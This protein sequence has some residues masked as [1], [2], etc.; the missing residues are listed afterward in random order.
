VHPAY[1]VI[2]FTTASGAGYGLLALMAVF[3]AAGALPPDLWLG[4]IGFGLSLGAITFGL[5][6]STFHL[7]HPERAWRAFSQWRSSWLSREGVASVATYVP[8]GLFGI[9]WVFLGDNRGVWAAFGLIAA[10]GAVATVACTAMIYASLKPIHAWSNPHVLPNYLALALLTGALWF[11]A[12][13]RVFGYWSPWVALVCVAAIIVAFWFKRAYWR[14]IDTTRGRPTVESATGLGALG[15]VRLLD[16]PNTQENYVQTEMGYTIA[17]KHA[18]KLRRI[19]FVGLFAVPL[20]LVLIGMD[21][22]AWLG[23]PCLVLAALSASAGVVVERWLFFAEAKH[24]VM[25]YYGADAA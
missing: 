10:A 12:L 20:V 23:I 18:A 2:F 24:A 22:P 9:G 4:L 13:V 7:G 14:F 21:A 19:A 17:R 15:K 1:S 5:L 6:S 3:A 25:L 16:P 11:G 8:A